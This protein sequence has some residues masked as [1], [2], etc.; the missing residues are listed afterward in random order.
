MKISLARNYR[1]WMFALLP[2]T[3]GLGSALLWLH[4]M[5]WPL[6]IDEAGITLR[7]YRRVGWHS[8][9]RIGVSRSYLDGHV[10]A[11]RIH[12]DRGVSKK[13]IRALADGD[14]VARVILGMFALTNRNRAADARSARAAGPDFRR[15]N[16]R[17]QRQEFVGPR[18]A[19]RREFAD[20]RMSAGH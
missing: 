11:I 7:N 20:L 5:Y 17:T 4:S 9:R 13:P 6:E 8:I 1:T 14:R 12:Y 3:L 10:S 15:G 16:A 18:N 19:Q 2:S